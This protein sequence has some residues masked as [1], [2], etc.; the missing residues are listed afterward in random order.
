[1]EE[2]ATWCS[3]VSCTQTK[4]KENLLVDLLHHQTTAP[5]HVAFPLPYTSWCSWLFT[6]VSNMQNEELSLNCS[7]TARESTCPWHFGSSLSFINQ[8]FLKISLLLHG[9]DRIKRLQQLIGL[10][11]QYLAM[12][13]FT[14][15]RALCKCSHAAIIYIIVQIPEVLHSGENWQTKI[16]H[17]SWAIYSPLVLFNVSCFQC[18]LKE[19]D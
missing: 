4:E 16:T 15:C 5:L 9:S 6:A 14:A 18:L 13:Y 8:Y 11:K 10:H 3:L 17:K 7:H 19:L 12:G 1:M 2:R